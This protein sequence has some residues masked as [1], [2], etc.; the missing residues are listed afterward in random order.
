MDSHKGFEHSISSKF[1]TW[2]LKPDG[3]EGLLGNKS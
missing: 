3:G 1:L 2:N